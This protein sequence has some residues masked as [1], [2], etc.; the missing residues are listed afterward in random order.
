MNTNQYLASRFF[1]MIVLMMS[2]ILAA[3]T[4][5]SQEMA[6]EYLTEE[7]KEPATIYAGPQS[8]IEFPADGDIL[9]LGELTFTVYSADPK[10]V[11]GVDLILNG[12]PLPP[13]SVTALGDAGGSTLVRVDPVWDPPAKGE[14]ILEAKAQSAAGY[15]KGTSIRFC[16]ETCGKEVAAAEPSDTPTPDTDATGTPTPFGTGTATVTVTGDV[17]V[18]ISF[19]GESP[20]T[21]AGDCTLLGWDVSGNPQQVLLGGAPVN[22]KGA[23]QIC[24]CVD[25]T[26]TLQ[27]KKGDGSTEKATVTVTVSGSCTVETTPPPVATTEAPPPD[28]SGPTISEQ[29]LV[30]ESC[31]FFGQATISD[32]AGVSS[33]KFHLNKNGEGWGSIW[34]SNIGGDTWQ[35]EVGI[36]VDDGMGTPVGTIEFYIES[37]DNNNNTSNSGVS[38]YNYMSCSG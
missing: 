11:V 3:C 27:V 36:S 32:P 13:A 8:W 14:Y 4:D 18:T 30:W 1:L 5:I 7:A 38:T 2:L 31:K 10:G 35:A 37:T 33:A 15:G 17:P 24:P 25:T 34:M 26:Y 23:L 16:I 9:P 20:Y 29:W 28:T 12:A 19:W 22:N 21:N 6:A